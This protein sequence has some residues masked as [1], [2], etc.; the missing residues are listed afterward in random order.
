MIELA[1]LPGCGKTAV[2]QALL[3]RSG[4]ASSW[5]SARR[6][7]LRYSLTRKA[8]APLT[9]FRYRHLARSLAK[10]E[11]DGG[12]S[13]FPRTVVLARLLLW[14]RR[15]LR[16]AD[17]PLTSI[18]FFVNVFATECALAS[19]EARLRR[20]TLIMDEGHVQHA[21]GVWLRCPG[22]LRERI[23]RDYLAGVP[24]GVTCIALRCAP[25]EALRRA[26]WRRRGVPKVMRRG[27]GTEGVDLGL[28]YAQL[29][30]LLESPDL[31]RH[32]SWSEVEA[33]GP[34]KEMS[35]AVFAVLDSGRSPVLVF[36]RN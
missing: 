3:S 14:P 4:V 18:L 16:S 19:L 2:C 30:E 31:Q 17:D 10:E 7:R 36:A 26:G 8:F 15:K 28:Q 21:L 23:V 13:R 34:A 33:R 9:L 12:A 1:G 22:R 35:Q 24:R 11:G 25:E 32:F 6:A 27:V 5:V 20:R 29:A